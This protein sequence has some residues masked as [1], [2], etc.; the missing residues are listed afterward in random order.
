MDHLT[1]HHRG[2]L[3][4]RARVPGDKSISH[5]AL[6][7]GSL[8]DGVSHVSGFLP[9]GDCLATLDCMRAL[10]IEVET[11]DPTTLTIHGRGPR[12][13]RPPAGGTAVRLNCA[14][15]GTTMRLLAGILAGQ[16]FASTLTGDEQ[17]LRRPMRRITD[18]LRSMGA[19]IEDTEGRAPL[20]IHG[21]RLHGHDHALAVASA[22]VKS[23][24]LLAG[25]YADGPTVVRQPG[26]ARD[27]TERMLAAMGAAIDVDGLIATLSPSPSLSPLSLRVPGDVSSAAF[28]LVAAA[29]VPGSEVTIEGVGV[30]PTRTGLLDVLRGMGAEITM[31]ASGGTGE[32][33][34]K[35]TGR[36]GDKETPTTDGRMGQGD[37]IRSRDFPIAP[38]IGG[39]EHG[40]EYGGEPVADITVRASELHGVEIGGHTVVRMIDEF[41]VLAVAATQA[42]GETRVR[43]AAELRVKE[44]DRIAVVSG[45]LRKMGAR[46]EPL[47]DGFV[48]QGPTPLRGRVVDSHNDHRLAMALAV[49][50][51]VAE[52]E[53]VI[54]GAACVSDSFPGFVELMQGLTGNE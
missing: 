38:G 43:D 54:E 29:L 31:T 37:G 46:I 41:P 23:A 53:T 20:H 33:G 52:G 34:D 51:L 11:Q 7:I 30:N 13:L 24:L 28:P 48:I 26:P 16:T 25:L 44:T 40:R 50:A 32:Q 39:R 6:L 47:P 5:R 2:P 3:R 21:R 22:Q 10:G 49:A 1:I 45:E 18:P 36:Q 19:H 14:R 42:R 15:S 35:G 27:H 9:S 17:L 12:G 4:G 8:A